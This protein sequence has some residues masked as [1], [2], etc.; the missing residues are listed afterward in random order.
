MRCQSGAAV[1]ICSNVALGCNQWVA[2]QCSTGLVCERIPDTSCVDP[3]WA[4]WPMPNSLIDTNLGAPNPQS[5]TDNHDGTVTDNVTRLMWQ[6]AV[7]ATKI[8]WDEAF[9]NCQALTLAGRDDWRLPSLIELM[10]ILDYGGGGSPHI[11]QVAFPSTTSGTYWSSIHT[12]LLLSFSSATILDNGSD[13]AYY[14]CVR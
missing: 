8:S 10:S 6:Q 12:S 14:R 5:Y 3:L 13:S 7:T 11:D 1:E 9:A 2:T 4:Q